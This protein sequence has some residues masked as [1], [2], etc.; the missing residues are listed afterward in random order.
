MARRSWTA[1][2]P[3]LDRS[4]ARKSKFKFDDGTCIQVNADNGRNR[5]A[6]FEGSFEATEASMGEGTFT[7]RTSC[8]F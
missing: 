7:F 8:P 6:S 4:S 5:E 1:P 2:G 3:A